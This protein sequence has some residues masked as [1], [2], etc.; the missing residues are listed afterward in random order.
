M[1]DVWWMLIETAVRA[2]GLGLAA[3][4][5]LWLWR[6]RMPSVRYTVWVGVVLG[7]LALPLL[8]ALAPRLTLDW[9]GPL[10]EARV[11][12]AKD[13]ASQAARVTSDMP[14]AMLAVPTTLDPAEPTVVGWQ[15]FAD[16]PWAAL[17]LTLYLAVAALML[18]S[19]ARGAVLLRRLGQTAR[20]VED[21]AM[22]ALAV[23]LLP[24]RAVTILSSAAVQ[25]PLTAG[26]LRPR[27]F[28]PIS[29]SNWSEDKRCAVLAHELSHVRRGDFLWT[30]LAELNTCLYWFHPLAWLA[31]RRLAAVAEHASDAAAVE[32]LGSKT[33]YARILVE[34]AALLGQRGRVAG[35]LLSVPMASPKGLSLR[36]EQILR[37]PEAGA[38]PRRRVPALVAATFALLVVL[39]GTV[40]LVAQPEVSEPPVADGVD[41]WIAELGHA[42]PDRRAR[43]AYELALDE[44]IWDQ[45]IP[46]LVALLG[47]DAEIRTAPPRRRSLRAGD[48]WMPAHV[49]WENPSPGE[50]AVV[51]LASMSSRATQPLIEAL[52]DGDPV[53]RRN[54]AWGLGELR[55]RPGVPDHGADALIAA[56]RDPEDSVRAAAAWSLG[57]IRVRR[58][59]PELI[60]TLRDDPD[61]R[62]RTMA[63]NALG[64][65]RAADAEDLLADVAREDPDRKVRRMA[66]W[67]LSEVIDHGF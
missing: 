49:T 31:R 38:A 5:A 56:L 4:L 30:L 7:M 64:E 59:I 51:S 1:T 22:R 6:G 45:A 12:A 35:A 3:G 63:A 37:L 16:L 39:A 10:L 29:W 57:D 46:H 50:V 52:A 41:G 25:V 42:D 8:T 62:V 55:N 28:L 58:A 26:F 14:A 67:A 65:I 20:P 19:L 61:P 9:V 44:S 11:P 27:V 18:L 32:R 2:G 40:E 48:R 33:A 36:V 24:G 13:A 66:R 53:V 17:L 15:R 43:A 34:I 60:A 21:P 54:A 47:D 23:E